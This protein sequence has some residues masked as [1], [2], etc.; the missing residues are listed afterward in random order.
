MPVIPT[1]YLQISVPSQQIERPNGL[2]EE[3]GAYL[4]AKATIVNITYDDQQDVSDDDEQKSFPAGII[5]QPSSTSLLLVPSPS[6]SN[7]NSNN[8]SEASLKRNQTITVIGPRF[9]PFAR[10]APTLIILGTLTA[11]TMIGNFMV[12]V[13][14]ATQPTLR[15]TIVNRAIASLAVAGF[16]VSLFVMPLSLLNEISQTW[17]LGDAIC[18]AFV[19]LDVCFC[20]ASILHL[21]AIAIDRYLAATKVTYFRIRNR[22]INI[23]LGRFHFGTNGTPTFFFF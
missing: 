11:L 15:K 17:F 10:L 19:F 22:T 20:T 9:Y 21:L 12:I 23:M 8:S 4:S 5:S 6:N 14:V 13:A 1:I 16:L 3:Y 7:N 2:V 18:D